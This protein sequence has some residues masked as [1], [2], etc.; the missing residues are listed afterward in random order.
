MNTCKA[1]TLVLA[2]GICASEDFDK[3]VSPKGR[4]ISY[5]ANF[6]LLMSFLTTAQRGQNLSRVSS[7]GKM[8]DGSNYALKFCFNR[9]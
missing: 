9:S 6:G 1:T 3:S 7:V 4:A 2:V 5:N 8:T